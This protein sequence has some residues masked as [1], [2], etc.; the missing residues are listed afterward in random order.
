MFS[1][2]LNDPIGRII[3]SILLGLGLASIFRKVCNGKSCIII[4]GPNPKEITDY[5][6]KI[7]EDCFKYTPYTSECK[8][9]ETE[10]K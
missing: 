6:Y 3:M 8:K 1:K 4:H 10:E 9:N 7:N 2:I 5:Y